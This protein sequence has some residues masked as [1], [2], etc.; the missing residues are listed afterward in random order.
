VASL[1]GKTKRL[2]A[3]LASARRSPP[4]PADAP[5]V[6]VVIPTYNWSAVL[7]HSIRTALWQTY[8]NIEVLVVGDCC[9]DDSE[10]VVNSFGDRR[11]RWHNLPE[12]S[13]S[14][15]GPNGAALA[16]A[17]GDFIAYLGHDDVWLPTHLAWLMEGVT[18]TGSRLA[19][20]HTV[21]IAP[22]GM[23]RG[24]R[25]G[26]API[27]SYLHESQLGREVGWRDYR[28]IVLGPDYDFIER[29]DALAGTLVVPVLTV[30]K[31]PASWRKNS[32]IEKPSHEQAAYVR[33]I[34][35][36]RGFIYRELLAVRIAQLR[37][38]EPP[39]DFGEPPDPELPGWRVTQLRKARG[40]E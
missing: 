11:L 18:Q 30:F 29:A 23:H 28:E 1:A 12:N 13:G 40:L 10:H 25:F 15:A 22:H 38:L 14:Q 17:R 33:R 7:R 39:L 32:Y 20:T 9:T 8:S 26:V 27:T 21:W 37:R 31:F 6:S 4:V 2:G 35:N 5:L 36:E 16:L 3:I 24:R 19:H 34:E